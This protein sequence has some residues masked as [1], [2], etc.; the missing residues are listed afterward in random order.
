MDDFK[1]VLNYKVRGKSKVVTYWLAEAAS[2]RSPVL[3]DEHQDYKWLDLNAACQYVIK[4]EDMQQML[5]D[6][7]NFIV[8]K[9]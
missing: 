6:A 5:K 8:K 3:S 1:T 4:F 7:Y 9:K 2:V